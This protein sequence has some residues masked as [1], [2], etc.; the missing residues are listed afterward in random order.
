MTMIL[1]LPLTKIIPLTYDAIVLGIYTTSV[2]YAIV[3]DANRAVWWFGI[4]TAVLLIGDVILAGLS[5]AALSGYSTCIDYY[6]G[7][8]TGQ[9]GTPI[10]LSYHYIKPLTWIYDMFTQFSISVSN[11]LEVHFS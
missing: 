2:Y 7:Y 5:G 6:S 10:D 8:H 9:C 11:A 1:D 3:K 4:G